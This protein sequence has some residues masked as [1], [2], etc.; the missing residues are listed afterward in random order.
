M[1]AHGIAESIPVDRQVADALELPALEALLWEELTRADP[2][3]LEAGRTVNAVIE[4]NSASFTD[5][6][7]ARRSSWGDLLTAEASFT[8]LKR[9]LIKEIRL[10]NPNV[11]APEL[12]EPPL[13]ER[14]WCE[15]LQSDVST[16]SVRELLTRE[17]H[18]FPAL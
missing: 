8:N 13:S 12:G 14:T 4:M 6:E 11:G 2:R 7:V 17:I 3:V 15:L 16:A 18:L 5:T 9:L 10:V 1:L